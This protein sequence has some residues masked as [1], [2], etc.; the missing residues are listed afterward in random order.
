MNYLNYLCAEAPVLGLFVAGSVMSRVSAVVSE[1]V[2]AF[3][4]NIGVLEVSVVLLL[5]SRGFVF[6]GQG[7]GHNGAQ[8]H[9]LYNQRNYK[10]QPILKLTNLTNKFSEQFNY[11]VICN[12]TKH[13]IL[14]E[15]FLN[16]MKL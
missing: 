16:K 5:V 13:N 10:N 3:A 11:I 4:W 8:E 2:L 1:L 12:S 14:L 9:H 15:A 7:T 6:I